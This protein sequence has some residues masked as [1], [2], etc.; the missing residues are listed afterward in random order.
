VQYP[1]GFPPRRL[2]FRDYQIEHPYNTYRIVG[3]PP[4]PIKTPSIR[5][6]EAVLD[7]EVHDYLYFC[8]A[9]DGSGTHRF[10]RTY[11]EHLANVRRYY[12]A[13]REQDKRTSP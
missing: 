2:S 5:A 10:A 3:L 13:L 11:R 8:K 9:G 7:P 6:I 12:R 1:L 4:G